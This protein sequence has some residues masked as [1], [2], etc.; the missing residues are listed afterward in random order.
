M[1]GTEL[2]LLAPLDN[3]LP[4]PPEGEVLTAAQWRTLMAIADTIIPCVEASTTSSHNK[5]SISASEYANAIQRIKSNISATSDDQAAERFLQESASSTPGFRESVHRQL[6]HYVR[7]DAVKGIV[8]PI[9]A[10]SG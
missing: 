10:S 9:Q 1:A 4:P 2:N 7:E 8:S 3:P 5:L 6:G